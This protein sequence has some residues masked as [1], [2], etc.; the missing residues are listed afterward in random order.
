MFFAV[1]Y[2]KAPR[3]I[4]VKYVCMY[5]YCFQSSER[6]QKLYMYIQSKTFIYEMTSH[7]ISWFRSRG[8]I[9]SEVSSQ[10]TPWLYTRVTR[11][12]T[13]IMPMDIH[14]QAIN[15]RIN[16]YNLKDMPRRHRT[17]LTASRFRR[18]WEEK[19][20]LLAIRWNSGNL[21]LEPLWF[22]TGEKLLCYL[23]VSNYK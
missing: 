10:K 8:Q 11:N 13:A 14:K 9:T 3:G 15:K 22:C 23:F 18:C 5:V 6:F 20:T 2:W 12:S 1:S 17:A 21:K 19:M 7:K 16:R 4:L